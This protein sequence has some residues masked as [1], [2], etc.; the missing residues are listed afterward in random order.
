MT[1]NI[2]RLTIAVLGTITHLLT[3]VY[4][5]MGKSIIHRFI[6]SAVVGIT[7]TLLFG[8]YGFAFYIGVSA[9]AAAY[10]SI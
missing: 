3:K 1:K 9:V 5:F 7:L 10:A 6:P 2:E 4:V 8:V